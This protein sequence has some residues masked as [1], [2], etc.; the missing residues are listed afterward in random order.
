MSG[1]IQQDLPDNIRRL[2]LFREDDHLLDDTCL[3]IT[4][5]RLYELRRVLKLDLSMK[6]TPTPELLEWFDDHGI[7]DYEIFL[8]S[9]HVA[10]LRT[11]INTIIYTSPYFEVYIRL[12]DPKVRMLFKLRWL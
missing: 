12:I 8:T 1:P 3:A 6:V 4:K 2:G 5:K 7:N 9:T 11:D 10:W